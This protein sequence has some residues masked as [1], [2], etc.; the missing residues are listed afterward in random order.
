[1]F[2]FRS[3]QLRFHKRTPG[4]NPLPGWAAAKKPGQAGVLGIE[5]VRSPPDALNLSGTPGRLKKRI[6]LTIPILNAVD[7]SIM[8]NMV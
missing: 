7:S 8:T 1:M 4:G 5:L 6:F 2:K 3:L